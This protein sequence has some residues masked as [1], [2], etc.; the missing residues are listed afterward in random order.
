MSLHEAS[1]ISCYAHPRHDA[2]QTLLAS[3]T[4]LAKAA[5]RFTRRE[6]ERA[7][8]ACYVLFIE[9]A[10]PTVTRSRTCHPNGIVGN[11]LSHRSQAEV[12]CPGR[13]SGS[14]VEITG[15]W[16]P[17]GLY[18]AIVVEDLA[19]HGGQQL[20]ALATPRPARLPAPD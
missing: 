16:P 20:R 8:Q 4:P 17:A 5:L 14:T 12:L 7:M 10:Q 1:L 6:H 18:P 3:T 2:G 19:H 11:S 9:S 13:A 15:P